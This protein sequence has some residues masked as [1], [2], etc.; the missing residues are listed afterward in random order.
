VASPVPVGVPPT[1]P[2][3]P[4]AFL[5][6]FPEFTDE[7]AYPV[8]IIQNYLNLASVQVS[9]AIWG[10]YQTF[11]TGLFV[12]HHLTLFRQRAKSAARNAPPGVTRGPIG[13]E[14]VN[15]ASVGYSNALAVGQGQGAAFW[16]QTSYGV[17][18]WDMRRQIGSG[19]LQL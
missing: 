6:A 18:F 13:S 2:V 3:T 7:G 19:G 1:S 16:N 11:Y 12:A 10:V 5:A 9:Y 17:E 4:A 14:S 8:P 15:G